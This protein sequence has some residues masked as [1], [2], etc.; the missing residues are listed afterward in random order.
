MPKKA[1]CKI[2]TEALKK[3]YL[4]DGKTLA[5]MCDIIGVKNTSTVTKILHERGI[6]TN[7]NKRLAEKSRNGM[8]ES[9]F[10]AF[11]QREYSLGKSMGT[12]GESLGITASA[13][14]KYFV[15]YEI[16]RRGKADFMLCD[17]AKNPNW[18]GG[19]RKKTAGY[20]EIY[21][22]DHPNA[23]KR[24]CVY[25]HQL[26]V[27]KHIGRYIKKGEVVHHIDGNKA[28]NDISNLLLLTSSEHAKLHQ[29][30]RK[31]MKRIN[32]KG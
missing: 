31:G 28:N 5:E 32:G 8:R 2:P 18:K 21:C 25:E 26:I 15:K 7:H 4:E 22:P 10:K 23:N 30:L 6:S 9:E 11:L 3:A 1:V 13:V 14:R 27:E 24:K 29:I 16:A 17:F 20:V 19:R 12:I